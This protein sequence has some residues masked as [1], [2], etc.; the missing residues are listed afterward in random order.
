MK[1]MKHSIYRKIAVLMAWTLLIQISFP[2]MSYALTSGPSQPEVQS[3]EPVGTSE[4]VDLFSGDFNYNIPLLE[5]GGYPL[6]LAYHAGVGL[7]DEASWVG[8]GWNLNPGAISRNMRGIPDDF[9]GEVIKKDVNINTNIT[10]SLAVR[11]E[12]EFLGIA[13]GLVTLGARYN[14]YKGTNLFASVNL[15]RELLDMG[16][17]KL[18]AGLGFSSDNGVTF[19]PSLSTDKLIY[20]KN[21]KGFGLNL[22]ASIN[23][24]TG[25][26]ELSFTKRISYVYQG[27][28]MSTGGSSSLVSFN[29]PSY[30]TGSSFNTES[31]SY[32]LSLAVGVAPPFVNFEGDIMGSF[33]SMNVDGSRDLNSYGYMYQELADPLNDLS[34]YNRVKD[35]AY[36]EGTNT[37]PLTSMTN[38][39]YIASGQG[40]SGSFRP[41]RGQIGYVTD[42]TTSNES[43]S[44]SAGAEI[45]APGAPFSFKGGYNLSRVDLDTYAGLWSRDNLA[46]SKFNYKT[47]PT[48][49]ADK[50]LFEP[51]YFKQLGELTDDQGNYN[52]LQGDDPLYLALG[53]E[54]NLTNTHKVNNKN[55]LN[56]SIEA[57]RNKRAKRNQHMSYR[58]VADMSIA[59]LEKTTKSYSNLPPDASL[60]HLLWDNADTPVQRLN[61]IDPDALESQ[62]Y[63]MNVTKSDGMRYVYGLPV[64][65]TVKKDVVFN[66][67][68]ISDSDNDGFIE[69]NEASDVLTNS[70]GLEHFSSIEEV[71]AYAHSYMLTA[72]LSSDYIDVDG[73]GPSDND[74]GSWTKFN[75]RCY[76]GPQS[77]NDNYKWRFPY[78]E[79]ASD[80]I[81]GVA[82]LNEGFKSQSFD[83]KGNYIYGEKEL[84]YLHSIESKAHIAIFELEDRM[85]ALGV[86]N[87]LGSNDG[88]TNAV[89]QQKLKS[90]KHYAKTDFIQDFEN[91]VPLKTVHFEYDYSLCPGV[92]NSEGIVDDVLTKGK[93]TLKKLY[94]TYGNSLK[95]QY[96][97]YQFDY[98][99][100]PA[101]NRKSQDRWG[102]YMKEKSDE[103]NYNPKLIAN[104]GPLSNTDFPYAE[105]DPILADQYAAAWN[106]SK[107]DLPSGGIIN[108]NY[109]SDDYAFV[110][111]KR[112]GQMFEIFGVAKEEPKMVSD[113]IT[114][115]IS[116]SKSQVP[117]YDF[118]GFN[119]YLVVKLD[120]ENSAIDRDYFQKEY[121]K[122]IGKLYFRCLMDVKDGNYEFVPGYTDISQY[123]VF[124]ESVGDNKGN[125]AWIK[126]KGQE[127]DDTNSNNE[128]AYVNPIAK[129]TWQFAR[130]NI[131]QLVY[132]GQNP[133]EG[134]EINFIKGLVGSIKTELPRMING[135]NR[136][137]KNE[138]YA[139]YMIPSK[140]VVRLQNPN[141]K[142][143]GGG[144]R[145][146]SVY[147]DDNWEDMTNGLSTAKNGKYGQRYFYN[148]IINDRMVSSGVASYEP[149]LGNDE[150]LL[151]QPL[152]ATNESRLL[153]PDNNHFIEGPLGEAFYPGASVGYSKVTVADI[154]FDNTAERTATGY[155]INEFNT[156]K[157]YPYETRVNRGDFDKNKSGFAKNLFGGD[158]E[159]LM[160]VSQGYTVIIN[161][162]HGKPK[163][164]KAFQGVI[165]FDDGIQDLL[166]DESHVSATNYIS[167][168]E[169]IYKQDEDNNLINDVTVLRPDGT[170]ATATVG[171]DA[172]LVHDFRE[173]R[174]NMSQWE[175]RFNFD[176][177]VIPLGF[178]PIALHIPSIWKSGS[179]DETRFRAAVA[180]K[181]VSKHGLID[182][183]KVTQDGSTLVTQNHVYD[184]ETGQVLLTSVNN[185]YRD[186]LNAV[187]DIATEEDLIYNLS[188]PAHWAYEGMSSSATND[189]A[190]LLLKS[191]T[192]GDVMLR[193][194]LNNFSF[195][196]SVLAEVFHPGD[197][198][199]AYNPLDDSETK[200]WVQEVNYDYIKLIDAQGE[201][202]NNMGQTTPFEA[203]IIRSG[204]RNQQTTPI[205][206]LT[207]MKNPIEVLMDNDG[208]LDNLDGL[209]GTATATQQ[210]TDLE[211][212][213]FSAQEFSDEWKTSC[214]NGTYPGEADCEFVN[215]VHNPTTGIINI[216]DQ[217]VNG[218][219]V[220]KFLLAKEKSEDCDLE[221]TTAISFNQTGI[222]KTFRHT[223][224]LD[225]SNSL[226]GFH[227]ISIEIGIDVNG[228][229]THE[230]IPLF[231]PNARLT[232]VVNVN[233]TNLTYSGTN[234]LAFENAIEGV[235]KNFLYQEYNL[236]A[237]QSDISFNLS[238]STTLSFSFRNVLNNNNGNPFQWAGIDNDNIETQYF[239]PI[240]NIN[241]IAELDHSGS[242]SGGG[243][244]RSVMS[245]CGIN[246]EYALSGGLFDGVDIVNSNFNFIDIENQVAINIIATPSTFSCSLPID[247]P[248]FA[249][250]NNP[251]QTGA[252]GNW[253][254]NKSWI[255]KH[256]PRVQSDEVSNSDIQNK[257]HYSTFDQ[258]WNKPITS[259]GKWTVDADVYSTTP[260]YINSSEVTL[261]S[262]YGEA[263]ESKDALGNYS[264]AVLG[265]DNKLAIAVGSN[266]AYDKLG[267]DGFEEYSYQN[268]ILGCRT[269]L[270]MDLGVNPEDPNQLSTE[271]PHSGLYS[272]KIASNG[273]YTAGLGE[274]DCDPL[275]NIDYTECIPEFLLKYDDVDPEINNKYVFDGWCYVENGLPAS[276]SIKTLQDCALLEDVTAS[277]PLESDGPII[278]GWQRIY[279]VFELTSASTNA[280]QNE[281][282]F[283]NPNGNALYIDDVR[284]Y[285]FDANMKSFVYYPNSLKLMAELDENNHATYYEYDE[286]WNLIRV[287][288]ET[289]R[290]VVTLQE[291]RSNTRLNRDM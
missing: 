43:N 115:V 27:L 147:L 271:N 12:A 233:S 144:C 15:G 71:P 261:Y 245:S 260:S 122:D 113:V 109:E 287:K 40:M 215:T 70:R 160:T 101:Y 257:G 19:S 141:M 140:S 284:I 143:K 78:A 170:T 152:V 178:I 251:Y 95:G 237:T 232:G 107:I 134:N 77:D 226:V 259:D 26:S 190:R 182:K 16:G 139:R 244:L 56:V 49:E 272:L 57:V 275:D 252:K 256:V 161:D 214:R 9:A 240:D 23:S 93:L 159:D 171:I 229:I 76:A 117:L 186:K 52:L 173:H 266:T 282:I 11:P 102:C 211:V 4:M 167:A 6:N 106:L 38:D 68:G 224:D 288:K 269:K 145:V 60:G 250:N 279:Q 242:G 247:L 189:G 188:Y 253:R 35:G 206:S 108:I 289:E 130:L 291:N 5:V 22:G 270:H 21:P 175:A 165:P 127:Y 88:G 110:Q 267:F 166:L 281:I 156:S 50:L 61:S 81:S 249:E 32:N 1:K 37:L 142:K 126:L 193:N 221:S 33:S 132:P 283:N 111:D 136:S 45:G 13:K 58:T 46:K 199:I 153:A 187:D 62:I 10:A 25:L 227:F 210:A 220:T 66:S 36:F 209:S 65:N 92:P 51:N 20:A 278:D 55:G 174:S 90:I 200:L 79:Y 146:K 41:M 274:S 231:G 235:I 238:L 264:S 223:V 118:G 205:A 191:E 198:I 243:T 97:K 149:I 87:E 73:N 129:A 151:R 228:T 192:N 135:F 64:Y 34:D 285:P 236:L 197:E 2:T 263:L 207:S 234:E 216:A 128:A 195:S 39:V 277:G 286:E 42:I 24:R 181:I 172:E 44:T 154:R 80:G 104:D 241:V 148:E 18:N 255:H 169:Y 99:E 75:Y 100:N 176:T 201:P 3:F 63:E 120:S 158:T 137:L 121:L 265:Y 202:F 85:D 222:N 69:Y 180:T 84:W 185:E 28:S 162:M 30:T 163:A 96:S 196:S 54:H 14:T 218:L 133:E 212:L 86:K 53:S 225:G 31:N 183:V 262:P 276:V 74:F 47:T 217:E 246:I 103:V 184:S 124:H 258:F 116:D 98:D 194:S 179:E 268:N 273:S 168:Q 105:Q 155:T 131:P 89:R 219:V 208:D 82:N 248:C 213:D 83:D 280:N 290:G 157:D 239:N 114:D 125:Y 204:R 177:W 230:M 112:A 203:K 17:F 123:D 119:N 59:G 8:L 29:T 67:G 150:N 7:E 138:G 72:V 91:A 94:F 48:L 254:P 164:T